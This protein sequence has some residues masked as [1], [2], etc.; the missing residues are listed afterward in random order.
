MGRHQ[1]R[2]RDGITV[3]LQHSAKKARLGWGWHIL[4]FWAYEGPVNCT[5]EDLDNSGSVTSMASIVVYPDRHYTGPRALASTCTVSVS[6]CQKGP[7]LIIVGE[8]V[9]RGPRPFPSNV[10]DAT[11]WP[12]RNIAPTGL[13]V[14]FLHVDLTLLDRLATCIRSSCRIHVTAFAYCALST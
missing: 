4:P 6:H 10:D 11:V 14:H 5:S 12:L 2:F 1:I 8:R 13:L 7:L 9:K 3:D